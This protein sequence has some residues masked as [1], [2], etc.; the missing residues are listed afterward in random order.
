MSA[1]EKRLG[2]SKTVTSTDVDHDRRPLRFLPVKRAPTAGPVAP[3][4]QC[5]PWFSGDH[6][7]IDGRSVTIAHTFSAG[8]AISRVTDTVSAMPESG[9]EPLGALRALHGRYGLAML[10]AH[11]LHGPSRAPRVVLV[12]GITESRHSWDPLIPAL[13]ERFRLLTVDLR[14]HGESPKGPDYTPM[15]YAADVIETA[16]SVGWERPHMVG[17]SLGG[18]VVSAAA[19]MGGTSRVVNVDQPLNLG[20][21]K[22]Q[23]ATLEPMLRSDAATFRSALDAVFVS[24]DGPLPAAQRARIRQY[25]QPDQQVV[26]GTWQLM[27]ESSLESLN[28][29]VDTLSEAVKVPYLS[30]H[31]IDPGPEYAPWLRARIPQAVV[32]VWPGLGHY[33][34]LIEPERFVERVVQFLD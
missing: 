24:L 15:S 19:A 28:A 32:E 4:L 29:T 3:L 30:L 13:A 34:Q 14:G 21:L 10:L 20:A 12:H 25:G 16:A 31:G 11:E 7:P 17:H 1:N 33:P 9:R 18:V 2:G 26:L 23:L 5:P 22:E 27:L 6:D 8:A